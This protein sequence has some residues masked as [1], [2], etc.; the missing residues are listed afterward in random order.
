MRPGDVPSIWRTASASPSTTPAISSLRSGESFRWPRSIATP[1]PPPPNPPLAPPG[2]GSGGP[3]PG[4]G[5]TP[6]P[7]RAGGGE[8]QEAWDFWI[9]RGGTF[10]DVVG[11]RPDGTLVAHKLLSEN[12]EAYRDA[13]VQG[14]RDLLGLRTASRSRRARSAR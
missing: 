8:E 13:A 12:P 1:A 6:P 11:R 14:I 5:A 9:D 2:P 7:G 4:T 3:T 10:T